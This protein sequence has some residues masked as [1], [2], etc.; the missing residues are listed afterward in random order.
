MKKFLLCSL[1]L[2]LLFGCAHT[3]E[4]MKYDLSGK[5]AY[6]EEYVSSQANVIQVEIN[7]SANKKDGK[8]NEKKSDTESILEAVVSVGTAILTA[9]KISD[10]EESVDTYEL[11]ASVSDGFMEVL[12]TYV[13]INHVNAFLMFIKIR[14]M[15]LFRQ[16]QK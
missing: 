6:F 12:E 10:I 14:L 1:A 7:T 3:N 15:L 2:T 5:N 11:I 8:K 9:E 4:L 13:D 16:I